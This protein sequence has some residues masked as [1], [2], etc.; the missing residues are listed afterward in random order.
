MAAASAVC[1]YQVSTR[2]IAAAQADSVSW[3]RARSAAYTR[4]R[5]WNRYRS[6]AGRFQQVRVNQH[7]QRVRGRVFWL[8]QQRRRSRQAERRAGPQAQQ[9]KRLRRPDFAG[10]GGSRKAGETDLEGR[11]H[12]QV[13]R[14]QLI[15]SPS[16]VGQPARQGPHGPAPPGGEPGTGDPDRQR[17]A[18]AGREHLAGRRRLSADAL[19]AYDAGEQ[20]AGLVTREHVEIEDRAA[21]QFRQPVAGRDEHRARRAA[22]QQRPDLLHVA[23]VVEDDQDPLARQPGPELRGA[24]L[25]AHRDARG[26]GAQVTEEPGQHLGRVRGLSSAVEVGIQLPVGELTGQ[27]MRRVHGERGLAEPARSPPPAPP[28]PPPGWRRRPPRPAARG[29]ARPARSGR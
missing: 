6:G 10:C 19:R 26:V 8:T 17:Q 7:V 21:G 25:L 9:A 2:S 27:Q 12:R 28:G 3:V 20:G 29:A 15:Q 5:S 22:R 4:S 11:P 13:A 1:R 14:A 18:D 16:L 23:R 24:L